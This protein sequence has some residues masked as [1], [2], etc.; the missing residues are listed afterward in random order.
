MTGGDEARDTDARDTDARDTDARDTDA[1]LALLRAAGGRATATRRATI[2]VI[3]AAGGEHLN[4]EEVVARVRQSTPD[5]AESTI[6]RTLGALE[7]L[8]VITHVHLGHGP[9]IY[10]SAEPAHQH[11]VCRVC[12]Q[13]TEI[14]AETLADLA[15]RI[16]ASY[17]FA[18]EPLHFAIQGTCSPCRE[19][20][21]AES[22]A[23]PG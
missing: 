12:G 1:I 13:I 21:A 9:S 15:A 17:G 4:A 7:Q 2:D 23:T 19:G 3:L 18:I 11:L 14:P 6:Y 5:V 8:G 22:T 16:E 10:H 20:L